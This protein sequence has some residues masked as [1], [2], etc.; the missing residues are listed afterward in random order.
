MWIVRCWW[1]TVAHNTRK[2]IIEISIVDFFLEKKIRLA[3][4][5]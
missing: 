5:F 2:L 4:Y 1:L 3:D